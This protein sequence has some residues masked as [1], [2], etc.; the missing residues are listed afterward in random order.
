MNVVKSLLGLVLIFVCVQ[1]GVRGDPIPPGKAPELGRGKP[2]Y[3][4]ATEPLAF[5]VI[6]PISEENQEEDSEKSES[7]AESEY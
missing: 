1:C 6:P 7:G 5:P 3:K 4:R 2:N